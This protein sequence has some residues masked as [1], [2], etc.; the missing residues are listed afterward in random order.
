MPRV[1]RIVVADVAYHVTQRG[2]G[3]Q[4]ILASDAER[5]GYLDLLRQGRHKH[6]LAVLG[7]CLMSNHVHIVAIPHQAE[8]LSKILQQVQGRYAGY[9]NTAHCS[10]GHAWPGRFYSCPMD[11]GH[12]WTA[13]R[14]AELN[15]VRA[16]MVAKAV[17]WPWSSAAAHC[18]VAE[19]EGGLEMSAW[20]QQWSES[21]WRKFREEGESESELRVIRRCTWTGRPLGPDQFT[22]ALE[23]RTGRRLTP[24]RRGRP[25]K[26]PAQNL[27]P[28]L[29]TSPAVK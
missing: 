6:P 16:G 2:H 24:G 19:P 27:K 29:A 22:S 12:L 23:E 11:S 15:P 7:Y 26:T 9:W 17:D 14:Y 10:S 8:D 18:G 25:R 3:R 13:L 4:Y 28:V 20:R 1:A 21:A 5:L